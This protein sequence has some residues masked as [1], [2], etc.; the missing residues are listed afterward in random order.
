VLEEPLGH[1]PPK[2]ALGRPAFGRAGLGRTLLHQ[3]SSPNA[4]LENPLKLLWKVVPAIVVA[5]AVCGKI[6]LRGVLSAC[7]VSQDVIGFPPPP[8]FYQTAADVT[9]PAILHVTC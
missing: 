7:A 5:E 9:P 4:H 3:R 2:A 1:L 8:I 6:V